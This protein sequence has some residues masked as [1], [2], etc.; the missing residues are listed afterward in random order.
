M[1]AASIYA[2]STAPGRSAIA[3]IRISGPSAGAALLALSSLPRLPEARRAK[4]V[5]L[6]LS[7]AVLDRALCLWFPGPNSVTG[8]DLVE[9]HVHGGPAVVRQVL[10]ALGE[11]PGLRS[12]L[13]GEFTKRGFLNGKLDLTQAEGLADLID[14]ETE[15]QAAL[16]LSQ[17]D[18]ALGR[19]YESWRSRIVKGLAYTEAVIDF[20]DEDVPDSSALVIAP[21][22]RLVLDE[23]TGHLEDGNRG[24]ILREGLSVAIL[25]APNSGKSSLLNALAKRDIAI[26]SDIAG[27]TRDVLEARLNLKGYAVNLADTAGLRDTQEVIEREGI[28]RALARAEAAQVRVLLVDPSSVS[29][30]EGLLRHLRQGDLVAWSKSD[31][32]WLPPPCPGFASVA[33]S[34]LNGSGLAD[35]VSWL[36]TQAADIA[37]SGGGAV[38]SRARHREAVKDAE[39]SLSRG[40]ERLSLRLELAAEDFR[41][42]ARAI[43]RITG[44]VDVEDV[45][46]V[47]FR[48]FCIGK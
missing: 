21:D 37:G 17:M 39:T 41:L 38:I 23:M 26:V 24:E 40:L 34:T 1:D 27:T 16:A 20:P 15:Q 6:Q 22:L 13:P 35:L 11:V 19:L 28:K 2:L 31:L 29:E 25:G 18:G 47:V 44:R 30:L 9:L 10:A 5:V 48:D 32:G 8:E 3:I 43:G 4:T 46:D 7:G 42:A 45:L 36:A 14:A 33:I 12:A